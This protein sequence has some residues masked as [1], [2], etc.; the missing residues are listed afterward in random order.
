[1]TSQFAIRLAA[2]HISH[3][4]VIIYPTETVY[5]LG[6]D[7]TSF[8][9]IDTINSLKQRDNK[10]GLL[11]I[12]CHIDQLDGYIKHPSKQQIDLINTTPSTTSWITAAHSKAPPWLVSKDGTIGF[13]ITSH[14]VTRRL[15]ELLQHP[16]ISTSAN[17]KGRTPVSNTLQCH[18]EFGGIV[19]FILTSSIERTES[20]STI[21]QLNDNTVLRQ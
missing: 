21:R 19:D 1:M 9:A 13:R 10:T 7:P 11:L 16:I 15:C 17:Y 6:C 12:A 3:N 2:H 18:Q 5:G 14:P 20:P 8:D 4:G